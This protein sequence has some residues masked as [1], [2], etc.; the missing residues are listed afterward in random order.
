[1]NNLKEQPQ[2]YIKEYFLKVFELMKSGNQYPINIEDVWGL[3]YERRDSAFRELKI[4]FIESI[5]YYL[6]QNEKVVKTNELTNGVKIE[7]FL[8]V[9]CMEYLIARRNRQVFEVYRQVFH[10]T[11]SQMAIPK[12]LSE[13]LR[14]AADQAEIIETH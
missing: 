14:L 7:V 12:K 6:R 10:K 9:P 3:V 2:N 4:N 11:I 8:T 1:M 5:D 13:A